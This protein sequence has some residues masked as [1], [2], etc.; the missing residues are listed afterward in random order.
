MK[1]LSAGREGVKP[2]LRY[3]RVIKASHSSAFSQSAIF[4]QRE[5]KVS[6]S[7]K[8]FSYIGNQNSY[9]PA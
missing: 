7:K 4:A 2:K 1:I 6:H 3:V 5:T 8:R 9:P